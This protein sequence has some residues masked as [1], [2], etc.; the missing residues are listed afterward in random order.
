MPWKNINK[1]ISF[2]HL[3]CCGID[4]HKNMVLHVLLSLSQMV[5]KHMWSTVL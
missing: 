4:V 5:N 2:V 1:N 3:I